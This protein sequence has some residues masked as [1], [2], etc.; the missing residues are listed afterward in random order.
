MK[1]TENISNS[2]KTGTDFVQKSATT[3]LHFCRYISKVQEN[4]ANLL[5][6]QASLFFVNVDNKKL[7]KNYLAKIKSNIRKHNDC[8]TCKNFFYKYANVV[9]ITENGEIKS[10]IWDEKLAP[11]YLSDAV[12][13][14]RNEVEKAKVAGVFQPD[15]NKF[16]TISHGGW[17]HYGL[18]IPIELV[19]SVKAKSTAKQKMAEQKEDFKNLL[20][21]LSEFKI[22]NLKNALLILNADALNRSVK[23]IGPVE[24]LLER[25]RERK[26]KNGTNLLWRAVASAPAG[27]CSPRSGMVGSLLTDLASG[28]NFEEVKRSF[29]AKMHPLQYQRPQALPSAGNI[30]AAEKLFEKLGLEPALHRK[31]ATVA[32]IKALW[33]PTLK[34]SDYNHNGIFSHLKTK[35]SDTAINFNFPE[36]AI[37]WEKF[38]SE[39][40]PNVKR[41][42]MLVPYHG[43]FVALTTQTYDDAPPILKWDNE[44]NRNPVSWYVYVNGSHAAHWSL[45]NGL[46]VE[47]LALTNSPANWHSKYKNSEDSLVFILDGAKDTRYKNTGLAIFPENLKADLHEVRSTIEAYSNRGQLTMPAEL[48]PLASGYTVSKGSN[49]EVRLKVAMKDGT[50]RLYKLDRWD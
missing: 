16:G 37:T 19:W 17:D 10:L 23:F 43:S 22:D 35:E 14:I 36:K 7:W 32:D 30:A 3:D 25:Q 2:L 24:W 21:A 44:A 38:N 5:K 6:D 50:E 45:S 39:V 29:N 12:S 20:N 31:F 40:L 42:M 8:N 1:K 26:I 41:M 48:T 9:V 33:K 4:S 46:Y 18:T 11:D 47:V 15:T 28:K 49:W 13:G 27:W 34:H